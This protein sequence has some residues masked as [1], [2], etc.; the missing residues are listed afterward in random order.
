MGKVRSSK[1]EGKYAGKLT[2]LP[3]PLT[4]TFSIPRRGGAGGLTAAGGCTAGLGSPVD[5]V[6][7]SAA[8]MAGRN[9]TFGLV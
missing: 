5:L 8:M 1:K 7:L 2:C 6:G 9:E 4:L 3:P